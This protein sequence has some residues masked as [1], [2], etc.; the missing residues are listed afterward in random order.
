MRLNIKQEK[1]I[2]TAIGILETVLSSGIDPDEDGSIGEAIDEL[3]NMRDKSIV[4]K[5]LSQ[6]KIFILLHIP[7]N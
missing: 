7:R 6:N 4:S 5:D 3:M 2:G 1:A